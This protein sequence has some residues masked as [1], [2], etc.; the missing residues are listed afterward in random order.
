MKNQFVK[1]FIIALFL[2]MFVSCGGS[3]SVPVASIP[4][5]SAFSGLRIGMGDN[6][7][8]DIIGI[9]PKDFHVYEGA[10]NFLLG[11]GGKTIVKYYKGEGRLHV[12]DRKLV[13]IEYDPTE[14]G[15]RD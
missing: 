1:I 15:Y 8:E 10:A 2:G 12:R 5:D 7:M 13:K 14:D 3:Q 9:R 4:A 11:V 6:Q